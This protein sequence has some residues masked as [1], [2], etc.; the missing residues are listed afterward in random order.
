MKEINVPDTIYDIVARKSKDETEYLVDLVLKELTENEKIETMRKLSDEYLK[1]A[2]DKYLN[3]LLVESGEYYWKAISYLLKAIGVL[4]N[5]E[6]TSYDQYYSMIELLSYKFNDTSL[7]NL[8][9]NA[10]RLHGEFH[11]RPQ[12][13][14]SFLAR[15][16]K[17]ILL[18]QKLK[19]ILNELQ[20]RS[21]SA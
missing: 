4:L 15:R 6:I 21:E 13:K 19:S 12:E 7:V 17:A 11:P 9:V 1:Y 3:D 2:E 10:E 18:I 5:Y 16:D 20:R 14:S 8:F